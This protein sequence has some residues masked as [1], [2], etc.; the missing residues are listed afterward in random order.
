MHFPKT[1]TALVLLGAVGLAS[2]AYG[3]GSASERRLGNGRAGQH[4][5][6]QARVPLRTS[7]AGDLVDKLGV[8]E[9]EL[10]EAMRDF[11]EQK[12]GEHRDDFANAGEALG[13]SAD[14]VAAA[15]DGVVEVQGPH[16]R[17]ARER[18]A[19]DAAA[20]R[21]ALDKVKDER[22]SSPAEFAE[23]LADELGVDAAKVEEALEALRPPRPPEH[24]RGAPL[25]KLA[26]A[27]DVTRAELRKA[28]R[29]VRAGANPAGSSTRRSSR[30]TSPIA[31]ASMPAT[32]RRRCRHSAP[33]PLG[34]DRA[35]PGGARV[36]RSRPRRPGRPGLRP[37]PRASVPAAGPG[38]LARPGPPPGGSRLRRAFPARR[39]IAL[40]Q[41][42]Q[43]VRGELERWPWPVARSVADPE[44]GE[45][46]GAPRPAPHVSRPRRQPP[47]RPPP[48]PPVSTASTSLSRSTP[49]HN[50]RAR[51]RAMAGGCDES[52]WVP[53][54]V[55]K[56]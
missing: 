21:D 19:V 56:P 55:W 22:P 40:A 1:A 23:A 29:E 8:D 38:R 42:P 11:G 6:G 45:Q 35:G 44:Q 41:P 48:R 14:K 18:R 30:R 24:H 5:N 37:R 33:Q 27:L 47:C 46:Q 54:P 28:L 43:R 7:T 13:V 4:S 2:A 34:W 12:M 53:G 3:I 32:S 49:Q 25:R 51:R 50:T 10:A 36:P 9:D 20:V 15:L 52:D 31:S 16:R 26:A 39:G 17:A